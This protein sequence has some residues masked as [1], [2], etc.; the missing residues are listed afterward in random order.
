MAQIRSRGATNKWGQG[1]SELGRADRPGPG[2]EKRVRGRGESGRIQIEGLQSDPHRWNLNRL[3]S[4][5]RPRSNGCGPDPN[6]MAPLGPA[7]G[8]RRRRAD[9]PRQST[10]GSG[11]SLGAIRGVWRTWPWPSRRHGGTRER[12]PRQSGLTASLDCSGEQLHP[13]Q[14][15]T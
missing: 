12:R 15:S 11:T 13:N 6:T 7:S 8:V 1:V 5:G 2:A 3:I 14:C 10:R 4:D 9:P